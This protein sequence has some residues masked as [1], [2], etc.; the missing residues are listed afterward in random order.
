MRWSYVDSLRGELNDSAQCTRQTLMSGWIR[1]SDY[2]LALYD[3]QQVAPAEQSVQRLAATLLLD[4]KNLPFARIEDLR[5]ASLI[6]QAKSKSFAA[7]CILFEGQLQLDL[8][9]L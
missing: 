6:L 1:R 8:L 4:P 2:C 5:S 3:I 7:G 9:S